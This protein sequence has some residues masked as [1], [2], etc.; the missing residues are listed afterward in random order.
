LTG[1]SPSTSVSFRQYHSTNAPYSSS[2]TRFS[3]RRTSDRSLGKFNVIVVWT[4][5]STDAQVLVPHHN[6]RSHWNAVGVRTC[7]A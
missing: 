4:I 7:C 3:Y 2:S 6:V 1:F 5:A